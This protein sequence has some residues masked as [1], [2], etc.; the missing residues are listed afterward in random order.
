MYYDAA[1]PQIADL[2][3]ALDNTN[4]KIQELAQIKNDYEQLRQENAMLSSNYD[5][6]Q[7]RLDT[8]QQTFIEQAGVVISLNSRCNQLQDENDVLA[9][10]LG[11]REKWA[12][13]QAK[14][15]DCD[16]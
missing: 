15:K 3:T 5:D 9:K 1:R 13:S 8:L 4:A 7:T 11:G 16:Q 6:L 10:R 2:Q 14:K 12:R